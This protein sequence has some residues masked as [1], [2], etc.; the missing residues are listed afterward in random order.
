MRYRLE[1]K[2]M[3]FTDGG[4]DK[5]EKRTS[6]EGSEIFCEE[7]RKGRVAALPAVTDHLVEE[8]RAADWAERMPIFDF[9]PHS[10]SVTWALEN[11]SRRFDRGL[12]AIRSQ[13]RTIR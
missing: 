9:V 1:L 5:L 10:F 11:G 4:K 7:D 6:L 2:K 3:L 12:R 8:D 13:F